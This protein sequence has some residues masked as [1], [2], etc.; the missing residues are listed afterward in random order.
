[1]GRHARSPAPSVIYNSKIIRGNARGRIDSFARCELQYYQFKCRAQ[2]GCGHIRF[3]S[4]N[5]VSRQPAFRYAV[6]AIFNYLIC[7]D[8]LAR[9]GSLSININ[10][11]AYVDSTRQFS[12][13][14]ISTLQFIQIGFIY[15]KKKQFVRREINIERVKTR[16]YLN[17]DLN[18]RF[19]KDFRIC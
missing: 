8:T 7:F 14:K 9:D 1:M 4:G 2:S 17:I 18:L 5:R 16:Y 10:K 11:L 3:Q 6:L 12:F 13:T 19:V 15:I